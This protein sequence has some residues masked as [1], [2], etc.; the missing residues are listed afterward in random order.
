MRLMERVPSAELIGVSKLPGYK[1]TFH[2][3]SV[4]GSGK[5]NM[6]ETGSDEVFGAVYRLLPEQKADLDSF[7]G[8]G[9][10]YIDNQIRVSV[11][12]TEYSCF[13]YL[14]QQSHITDDIVP[15]EWYKELVLLGA[16][17]LGLPASYIESID[18]VESKPD[19][20]ISRVQEKQLLINRIINYR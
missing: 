14:A 3:R 11:A 13:T 1:L 5:C 10:G 16:K 9:S 12:G 8:K 4:D 19:D 6:Y 7:E 20:K 15:Y 18:Q 17:Y 2:K